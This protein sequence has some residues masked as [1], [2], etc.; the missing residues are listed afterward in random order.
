MWVIV[1]TVLVLGALVVL[2]RLLLSIYRKGRALLAEVATAAGR[3][4][5][6]SSVLEDAHV[7]TRPLAPT[8]VFDDPA[9]LRR[10][11]GTRRAA[12]RA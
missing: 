6:V 8:T 7:L 3:L 10:E 11:L 2:G 1:W 5:E 9:A 4:E 12:R